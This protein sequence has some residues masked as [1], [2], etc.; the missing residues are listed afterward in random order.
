MSAGCSAAAAE[1]FRGEN[2]L[3]KIR[4]K[5]MGAK[6]RPFYRLVVADA[7]SPRDGRFIE[8]LG[9]YDPL[10]EPKTVKIDAE[11]VQ[12]WLDQGAQ[13]SDAARSLLQREGILKET[14]TFTKPPAPVRN[15]GKIPPKVAKPVEPPAAAAPE[16]TATAEKEETTATANVEVEEPA[17]EAE[18]LAPAADSEAEA[19]AAEDEAEAPAATVEKETPAV[20]GEK[21]TPPAK[22]EKETPAAKSEKG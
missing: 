18:V 16:T 10:T 6:K 1:T 14:R 3:V 11:K 12:K 22:A 7:R 15:P 8:Q 19:P 9:Y 17:A 4:L 5:R 13:P 2:T 21:E 20:K